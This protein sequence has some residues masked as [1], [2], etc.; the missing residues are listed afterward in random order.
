MKAEEL[1][2]IQQTVTYILGLSQ[3]DPT[4]A[5]NVNFDK[6]VHKVQN[7]SGAPADILRSDEEVA[8][9]RQGRIAAQQKTQ[10]TQEG[11]IQSETVRALGQGAQA[12]AK[13]G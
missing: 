12:A 1:N 8:Q 10:Q 2:G 7:L 5:D 4:V 6:V 9:I 3:T 11:K 13:A